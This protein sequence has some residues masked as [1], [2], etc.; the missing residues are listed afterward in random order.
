MGTR[1]SY[2]HAAIAK[3]LFKDIVIHVVLLQSRCLYKFLLFT[4]EII[5][6]S[7]LWAY[8]NAFNID[9]FF[10]FTVFTRIT[11]IPFERISGVQTLQ[12]SLELK[13][14]LQ[15]LL[16][17]AVLSIGTL[18]ELRESFRQMRQDPLFERICHI[19]E[20]SELDMRSQ[21]NYALLLFSTGKVSNGY[22]CI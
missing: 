1:Q 18:I 5:L 21:L 13:A 10:N 7:V 3:A 17:K 22:T 16:S 12:G 20:R 14:S 2:T 15:P 8:Q 9:N 4:F 11:T 6:N 19:L